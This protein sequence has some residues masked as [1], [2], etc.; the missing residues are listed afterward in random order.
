[1]V[2]FGEYIKR[3]R[4]IYHLTVRDLAIMVKISP[5]YITKIETIGLIPSP[6]VVKNLAKAF[7]I[8]T[9]FLLGFA[10]KEASRNVLEKYKYF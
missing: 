9:M 8:D 5:G 10:G 7:C 6:K 3:Y 2:T 4:E 1:M